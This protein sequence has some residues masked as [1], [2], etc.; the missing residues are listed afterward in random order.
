[1]LVVKNPS[2][3]AWDIRDLG[4]IPGSGSSPRGGHGN[5][6]LPGESPWAEEPGGLQSMGLQNQTWL[7]QL[8][9][10][11]PRKNSVRITSKCTYGALNNTWHKTSIRSVS[12]LYYYP[13]LCS[14]FR[15]I[16][17]LKIILWEATLIEGLLDP[18]FLVRNRVE[19]LWNLKVICS[20]R[21]LIRFNKH[22]LK[23]YSIAVIARH[24]YTF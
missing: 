2:A 22:L 24:I 7:K 9:T 18:L 12:H 13:I 15:I 16:F 4:L 5:P 3:N 1:M 8:S 17:Y 6:L 14:M 20:W 11:A 10:H 23:T 21:N 19:L